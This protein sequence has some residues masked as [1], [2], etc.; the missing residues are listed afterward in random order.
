MNNITDVLKEAAGDILTEEVLEQIETIF[1]EQ[2]EEKATLRVE[3]A[4]VEQDETH[5]EKLEKLLEAIDSDHTTKL[6]KIIEAIDQ[7]HGQKLVTI[8]KKYES[9]I[10]ENADEF[11]NTLVESIS[12]YLEEYLE[13]QVPLESITEAVRNKKA[14]TVLEDL[15]KNLAVNFALSKDYIKD[16]IHDGKQQLDEASE[17][18]N[19]LQ[20]QNTQLVDEVSTLKSHILLNEKAAD[21]PEEKKKYVFRILQDKS[22][23]FIT[24]NFDYTLRLFDKTEEQKLEEYKQEAKT[25]TQTQNVDRPILEQTEQ[26]SETAENNPNSP[27]GSLYM[28]ELNKF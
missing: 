3:K 20:E 18:A 14:V 24:E 23:D 15:R 10:N 16:A 12:T 7:N 21:L 2:V 26:T 6:E 17:T 8:V 1:N 5:A 25:Q 28:S 11:K 4:L 27:F 13:E 19:S 22:V 9:A